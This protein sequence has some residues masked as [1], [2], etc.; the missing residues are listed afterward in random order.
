MHVHLHE[1]YHATYL[2]PPTGAP[3]L[4][5]YLQFFITGK[6]KEIKGCGFDTNAP[7][8]KTHVPVKTTSSYFI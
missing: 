7:L 6:L 4:Q 5:I 2:L 3:Q 1:R 8:M